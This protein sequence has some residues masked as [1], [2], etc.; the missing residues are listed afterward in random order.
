M[1]VLVVEDSPD[2][3]EAVDLVVT[4]RWPGATI[5]STELRARQRKPPLRKARQ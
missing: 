1:K 2:I 3:V 4:M 5:L